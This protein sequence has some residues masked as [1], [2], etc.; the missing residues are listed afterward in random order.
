M[1]DGFIDALDDDRARAGRA[2]LPLKSEG[3]GDDSRRRV[4]QVRVRVNDDG[5]L[6]AH[7]GDDAL[8]PDLPV[9]DF[10]RA[11]D[12]A[13]PD[14]LRSREGDVARLRV[15]NDHVAHLAAR[16]GHEVDDA[17]G[18]ARLFQKL[19]E[20][21]G[22]GRRVRRGLQDDGVSGD[23]RGGGH[24]RHDGEREVP[25]RDDDA[26]AE[27]NV[28]EPIVLALDTR[29]R[30]R[31]GVAQHLSRVELAEVYGLGG[32][33]VGLRPRLRHLVNHPRGEVVSA[34]AQKRGHA[35]Q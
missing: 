13:Q 20:L 10:R 28:F 5:I 24:P 4:V 21:V 26:D 30:L 8:D 7:L 16:P 3:R 19:E 18:D 22:D 6:A 1:E 32:V 25:R 9:V 34:L 17:R 12:D 2:L 15:V 33:G 11:L 29:Q 14:L 31:R 27:R 35:E 23:E